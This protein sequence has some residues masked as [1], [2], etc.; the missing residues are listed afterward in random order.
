[1]LNVHV[2]ILGI[3]DSFWTQT[4]IISWY[5]FGTDQDVVH[6]KA[7]EVVMTSHDERSSVD[8]EETQHGVTEDS[9][10]PKA[11]IVIPI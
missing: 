5:L 4:I 1:M 9:T 10:S 11:C 3:I 8:V 7:E 6:V 2:Y